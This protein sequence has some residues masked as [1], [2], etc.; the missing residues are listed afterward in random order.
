MAAAKKLSQS[1]EEGSKGE[2][3]EQLRGPLQDKNYA[4]QMAAFIDSS[5][6]AGDKKLPKFL[7]LPKKKPP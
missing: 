1:L 4:Y 5:F 6:Y 3:M 2:E 7:F